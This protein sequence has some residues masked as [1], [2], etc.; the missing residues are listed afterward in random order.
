QNVSETVPD[1]ARRGE[2]HGVIAVGEHFATELL[3]RADLAC[4]ASAPCPDRIDVA[5]GRDAERLHPTRERHPI[6]RLDEQ[7]DVRVLDADVNDMKCA[8][9]AEGGG[10]GAFAVEGAFVVP[11][12]GE[13]CVANRLIDFLVAK[14]RHA[15]CGTHDDVLRNVRLERPAL[16]VTFAR[17]LAGGNRPANP[18]T[19]TVTLPRTTKL[20]V[21]IGRTI[22]VL[23]RCLIANANHLRNVPRPRISTIDFADIFALLFLRLEPG[24]QMQK[25][26]IDV[27][28]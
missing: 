26:E 13:G 5:R 8:T 27:A 2:L 10:R 22:E 20:A 11:E 25:L 7:V 15:R 1:L 23:E 28:M 16:L 12:G 3:A 14:A 4:L 19:L 9:L 6:A 17:S 21:L 18:S 24:T